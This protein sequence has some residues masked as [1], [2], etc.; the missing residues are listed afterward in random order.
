MMGDSVKPA[1]FR[2]IIAL[3]ESL[4]KTILPCLGEKLLVNLCSTEQA[5][6]QRVR[7]TTDLVE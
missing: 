2:L 4:Q 3:V 1:G 7:M 5:L 6:L